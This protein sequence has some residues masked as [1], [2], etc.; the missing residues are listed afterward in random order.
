MAA[1]PQAG[2]H[3]LRPGS[4]RSVWL[5]CP[6]FLIQ[7]DPR[8][9]RQSC[10][11]LNLFTSQLCSKSRNAL[12]HQRR[13]NSMLPYDLKVFGPLHSDNCREASR[14]STGCQNLRG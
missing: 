11:C 3:V 1:R 10:K 2:R 6:R 4:R 7:F 13:L 14:A 8:D 5:K 12:V 9:L